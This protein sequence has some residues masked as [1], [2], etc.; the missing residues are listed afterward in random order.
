MY[1][2]LDFTVEAIHPSGLLSYSSGH[3]TSQRQF[4]VLAEFA[5]EFALRLLGK[6]YKSSLGYFSPI[7]PAPFPFNDGAS[8]RFGRLNMVATGFKIDPLSVG[9][10]C[11]QVST[12]EEESD[13][14]ENVISDPTDFDQME[15]YF[16]RGES[17]DN[18]DCFSTVTITYEENPCDCCTW[19]STTKAWTSHAEILPNT[20][21]SVER[22]PAYEMFTLPNANLVW[23]NMLDGQG[24]QVQ[25]KA[26]SYAYKIV[27]KAD[28]IVHWHNVPVMNLC[29]IEAHLRDFRGTVNQEEWGQSILCSYEDITNTESDDRVDCTF[30]EPE[31][32]LFIDFQED[33]SKRT[34]AFGGNYSD[35]NMNTTTLKLHFKQKRV[36]FGASNSNSVSDDDVAGDDDIN[37]AIAGWN[38]LFN[39]SDSAASEWMRVV[40]KSTQEPIFR[41][42]AFSDIMYPVL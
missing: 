6:Y 17:A 12:P 37:P 27:P 19:D 25:L 15:R 41:L 3:A 5:E 34:D 30:Y 10:G 31:T 20:C 29:Q 8:A 22:N 18:S 7:L 33:R 13:G 28:I 38:H 36:E 23:K 40:V 39:D 35:I 11:F 4:K 26:D 21:I 2:D 24:N 42:R 32:I 1:N 14:I 16:G 9:C